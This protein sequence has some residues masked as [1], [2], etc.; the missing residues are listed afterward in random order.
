MEER[1]GVAADERQGRSQLVADR[2]DEAFA[3]LLEGPDGTDVAHD[4]GGPR[5]ARG[6]PASGVPVHGGVAAGDP[7]RAAVGAADGRLAVGDRLP[8]RHD[9][10]ERTG[11]RVVPAGH[12][13]AEDLAARP[14][15]RVGGRRAEQPLAGRVEPDDPRSASTWRMRSVVPLTT[16]V[17]SWRSRSR[18]SRS[19]APWNATASS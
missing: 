11:G 8:G 12:V 9:L 10:G 19:R 15:E 14:A 17:S 13:A 6:S 3:Q 16:A 1:L 2:R 4:G 7:D 18:T 5:L